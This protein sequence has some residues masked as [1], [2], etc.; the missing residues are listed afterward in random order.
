MEGILDHL[1]ASIVDWLREF[2]DAVASIT[3]AKF[4]FGPSHDDPGVVGEHF[5]EAARELLD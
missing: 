2:Q 3:N 1:A 5:G 4:I